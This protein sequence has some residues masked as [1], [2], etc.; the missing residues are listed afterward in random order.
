[1]KLSIRLVM[2]AALLGVAVAGCVS[3]GGGGGRYVDPMTCEVKN[4][5]AGEPQ[6][7]PDCIKAAQAAAEE[8]ARA[9]AKGKKK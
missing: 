7:D 6:F 1:M 8:A 3:S 4:P 9:R 2:G 5:R